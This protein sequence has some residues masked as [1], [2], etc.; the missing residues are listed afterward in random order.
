MFFGGHTVTFGNVIS[1]IGLVLI[2]V[3]IGFS[4]HSWKDSK[5]N[6]PAPVNPAVAISN[7]ETLITLYLDF[8]M[9][10]RP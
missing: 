3:V 2:V 4:S 9:C 6:I 5:I 8:K 10:A 1:V 7:Q